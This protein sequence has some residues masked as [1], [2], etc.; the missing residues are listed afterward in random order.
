MEHKGDPLSHVAT[1]TLEKG[2]NFNSTGTSYNRHRNIARCDLSL[3]LRDQQSTAQFPVKDERSG[4]K[5]RR[6]G[7]HSIY[8]EYYPLHPQPHLFS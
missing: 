1:H 2:H 4:N 7:M 6:R 8:D 5:A 3:R